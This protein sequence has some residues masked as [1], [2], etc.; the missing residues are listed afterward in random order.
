MPFVSRNSNGNINGV[1]ANRQDFAAE[2]LP[3]NDPA[4]IAFLN[5]TVLDGVDSWDLLS[6]RLAFNHENRIR[7]IEGK[8]AITVAQFKTA[9]RT[10][11]N[12]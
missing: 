5:P 6:L 4:I 1:F 11:L 2:L 3:D 7:A 10:I 9:L 12:G 8:A